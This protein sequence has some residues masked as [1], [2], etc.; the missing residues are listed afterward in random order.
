MDK[1]IISL[2]EQALKEDD[3]Q[4]DIT[5]LALIDNTKIASGNFIARATGVLSGVNIAEAVFKIVNKKIEFKILRNNGEYVNRGDVIAYVKGPLRDILR[6][7]RVALNFLQRLSG[8]ATITNKYV[9]E[10]KGTNC[11]IFNTRETT[12]L[13][14]NLEYQAVLDGGGFNHRKSL[15]DRIVI[16]DN[17]LSIIDN[18]KDAVDKLKKQSTKNTLIEVEVETKEE[19]LDA[20]DSK[21]DTIL[22]DNMSVDLIKE[23]VLLNDGAKKIGVLS[24]ANYQ[25]IRSIALTGVDY[26]LVSLLTH[27]YK[28]LDIKLKFYKNLT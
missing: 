10:V 5:T 15:S 11:L 21:C 2:I 24:N 14:R 25:K 9:M 27:S 16:K 12:P 13:L 8:I 4:N 23:L 6:A 19:F 3:Y 1:N 17:H 26:I 18:I 20:L 7:E 22:L 28:N